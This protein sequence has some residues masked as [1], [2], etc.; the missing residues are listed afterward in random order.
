MRFAEDAGGP[1]QIE[2]HILKLSRDVKEFI[3][4]QAPHCVVS[5]HS[6]ATLSSGL[7][8]FFPFQ[9]DKPRAVFTD[10]KTADWV[11]S[12]LLKRKIQVRS[13]GFQDSVSANESSNSSYAIRVSTA[14]FNTAGQVESFKDALQD[15]LMR[16]REVSG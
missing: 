2:K 16:V 11:V 1:A 10:R 6:D 5:P 13:I 12:E 4:S 9:W 3:L 7:T 15:V 14:Y 8:A